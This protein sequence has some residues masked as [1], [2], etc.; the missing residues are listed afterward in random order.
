[1]SLQRIAWCRCGPGPAWKWDVGQGW[2]STQYVMGKAIDAEDLPHWQAYLRCV[3]RRQFK[4]G[5]KRDSNPTEEQKVFWLLCLAYAP[6]GG[7][8]K[9]G[10]LPERGCSDL[11]R[12]FKK[13]EREEGFWQKVSG[14]GQSVAAGGSERRRGGDNLW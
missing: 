2:E 10:G 6:A 13:E 9:P 12:E 3:S 8:E 1:M 4:T 5:S 11:K 14:F 7:H